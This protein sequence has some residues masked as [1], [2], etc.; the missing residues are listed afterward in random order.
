MYQCDYGTTNGTF[1]LTDQDPIILGAQSPADFSIRYFETLQEAMDGVAGTEIL[2]GV[3]IIDLPSPETI[4]ARI[5]DSA[6]G[7]CFDL[8]DFRIYFSRAIAGSLPPDVSYCDADGDGQ[9][10]IDLEAEF[11]ALVLDGQPS[12]D[13]D[14]TYHLSQADADGDTGALSMPHLVPAPSQQIFVRLENR[15]DGTCV[16]T[17]QNVTIHLD[18]APAVNMSPPNL[19]MCDDN[20]DGFAQFDLTLQTPVI[21]LGDPTLQVTYHGTLVDAQNGVL[22]LPNPYTNDRRYLDFPNTDPSTVGYGTGG[23]WARVVRPGSS[24]VSIVPFALEVRFSPV[25]NTPAEPLRICD[26]GIPPRGPG[27]F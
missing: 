10:L 18:A 2:G 24:C 25:G 20:N 21:T 8:T 16:D 5:E 11:N 17:G 7:T 9:E 27:I 1:L 23:V 14:I 12:S 22:P 6:S 26:D 15:D 4:W 13:Y 19:V 3:K